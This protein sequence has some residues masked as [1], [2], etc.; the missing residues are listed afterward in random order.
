[1]IG[2]KILQELAKP[3]PVVGNMLEISCSIGIS[4]YPTDGKDIATLT[5]NAD[6]AM[7]HAKKSGKRGFRLFA[8][9]M[10]PNGPAAATG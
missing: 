5:A 10:R 7:Y 6:V 3:I 8:P 1:V 9:D 2:E 4:M